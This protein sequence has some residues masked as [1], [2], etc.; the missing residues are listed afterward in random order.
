[1]FKATVENLE[2]SISPRSISVVESRTCLSGF[3]SSVV[4]NVA[5]DGVNNSPNGVTEDVDVDPDRGVELLN[6]GVGAISSFEESVSRGSSD[7]PS[8]VFRLFLPESEPNEKQKAR[9]HWIDRILS[10]NR[11][12]ELGIVS[13]GIRRLGQL[14]RG[15]RDLDVR[16][17]EQPW[18]WK[19][20]K[21]MARRGRFQSRLTTLPD[22][23]E[24]ILLR[25]VR[26]RSLAFEAT[27]HSS[28]RRFYR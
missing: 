4:C 27:Q 1:M 16:H 21:F 14:N 13:F 6:A 20:V 17:Q 28:K 19:C 2:S 9:Q 10:L 18:A 11:R 12:T 15:R 22:R 24:C 26:C 23:L 7:S 5:E 3:S 8:S 25:P